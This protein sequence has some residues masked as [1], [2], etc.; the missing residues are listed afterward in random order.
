MKLQGQSRSGDAERWGLVSR[1]PVG[2]RSIVEIAL[3]VGIGWQIMFL[4]KVLQKAKN[5]HR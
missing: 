3:L 2:E 4:G 5:N 1:A